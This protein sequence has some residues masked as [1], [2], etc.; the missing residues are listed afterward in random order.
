MYRK[1]ENKKG[2]SCVNMKKR[3]YI[4]SDN[5]YFDELTIKTKIKLLLINDHWVQIKR[6]L[7]YLRLQE[8]YKKKG[9]KINNLLSLYWARRKNNLGNKLGFFIPE[10]TLGTGVSI[11]HHGSIIINGDA[12]IGKNCILHGMNCIGNDGSSNDAPIIGESV[13]IGVGAKIIGNVKVAN[14]IKIGANAIVTKN[15]NDVGSTLVG[16]PAKKNN[17]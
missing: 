8:Y 5:K 7:K 2:C 11:Y 9:G 14:E 10:F 1:L 15:F 4:N 16:V 6:F 3:E 13:D 17:R 12:R